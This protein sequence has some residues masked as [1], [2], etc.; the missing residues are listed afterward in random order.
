MDLSSVYSCLSFWIIRST[1]NIVFYFYLFILRLWNVSQ[2][3]S[4]SLWK[5]PA[6]AFSDI[7][8]T[9]WFTSFRRIYRRWRFN[10]V[11]G[12]LPLLLLWSYQ[13]CI[14]RILVLV[15]SY[16]FSLIFA[17]SL[18]AALVRHFVRH[19]GCLGNNIKLQ[20]FCWRL[21]VFSIIVWLLP[22]FDPKSIKCWPS[23]RFDHQRSTFIHFN[24]VLFDFN[25]VLY[26]IRGF[27]IIM[28]LLF[29]AWV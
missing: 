17:S 12:C 2:I 28:W 10:L 24:F 11:V 16:L 1:C 23:W 5:S 18:F 21:F 22:T 3:W 27:L 19:W 9:R 20:L 14:I 29:N 8:I 6:W 13:F 7:L 25:Q 15:W 26:F 4:C